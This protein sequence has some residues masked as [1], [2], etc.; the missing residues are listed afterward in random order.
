M[1]TR[2]I[3]DG[4]EPPL[5]Q[6]E[7][8]TSFDN[9][10]KTLLGVSDVFTGRG[11]DVSPFST[12]SVFV[13][14]NQPSALLGISMQFSVDGVNWDRKIEY[15]VPAN[16]VQRYSF[17]VEAQ[18]F[19]IVYTN[20]AN[21]QTAFRLQTIYSVSRAY[22]DEITKYTS[23]VY[24]SVGAQTPIILE[25]W[26]DVTVAIKVADPSNLTYTL[27]FKLDPEISGNWFNTGLVKLKSDDT[28]TFFGRASDLRIFM[29]A[30][31]SGSI[32][33][34]LKQSR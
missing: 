1:S 13:F 17:P 21:P 6:T 14:C 34:N 5:T 30:F 23:F 8:N 27:Q 28:T 19:R 11:E 31:N 15:T 24:N 10:T 16:I 22:T 33:L 7:D 12:V 26:K 32:Q 20:S 18:F 9:S 25:G 29:D 4:F 3:V 2:N